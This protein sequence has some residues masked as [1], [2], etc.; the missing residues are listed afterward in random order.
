MPCENA[1]AYCGVYGPDRA[2]DVFK[3]QMERPIEVLF[4]RR[5]GGLDVAVPINVSPDEAEKLAVC[6]LGV[7][8][9]LQNS[10]PTGSG[11]K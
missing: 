7:I 6:M 9:T 3:L 1:N 11:R 2:I 4:N 10:L 5:A 8:E